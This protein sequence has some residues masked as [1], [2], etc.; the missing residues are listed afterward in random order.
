MDDKIIESVIE[1]RLR[2]YS[3]KPSD[4][5]EEKMKRLREEVRIELEGGFVLDGV[6]SRLYLKD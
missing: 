6:L 4:L 5:S 2:A 1:E 3:M